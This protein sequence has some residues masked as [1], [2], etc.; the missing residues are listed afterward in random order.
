MNIMTTK[1]KLMQL[2]ELCIEKGLNYQIGTKYS[3]IEV[4][5]FDD[6]H[7]RIF[8]SRSYFDKDEFV[9]VGTL[10]AFSDLISKVKNYQS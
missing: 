10:I 8:Y 7:E 9:N 4:S 6:N 5:K 1:E 2:L 3:L